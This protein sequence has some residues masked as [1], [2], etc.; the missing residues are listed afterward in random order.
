MK[1]HRVMN[2]E[3]SSKTPSPVRRE[4]SIIA[5][6]EAKTNQ[7]FDVPMSYGALEMEAAAALLLL[8]YQYDRQSKPLNS[9]A[10][11]RSPTPPHLLAD[12]R[13]P[14]DQTVRTPDSV[15]PLKKRSIPTHLLRRSL[16]PAKSNA[17]GGSSS[18]VKAKSRLTPVPR[19]IDNDCN[20]V[21]LKSCRN[22]IREFLDNQELI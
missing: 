4:S 21:L 3:K 19:R 6:S 12:K 22:M 7:H 9:T 17:S 13:T 20:K 1:Y 16:T 8:R 14:K 18:I 11:T 10:V 15:Q 5:I 2:K